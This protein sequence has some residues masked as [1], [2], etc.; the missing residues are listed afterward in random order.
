MLYIFHV[1][2]ITSQF[3]IIPHTDEFGLLI[4]LGIKSLITSSQT[5]PPAEQ[6]NFY[7]KETHAMKP[8]NIKQA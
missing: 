4:K 6:I 2:I 7:I 8:Y 3:A 1:D 5:S